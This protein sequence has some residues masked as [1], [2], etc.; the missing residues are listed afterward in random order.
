[1]LLNKE[2]AILAAIKWIAQKEVLMMKGFKKMVALVLAASFAFLMAGCCGGNSQI[3]AGDVGVSTTLDLTTEDIMEIYDFFETE[4]ENYPSFTLGTN[5]NIQKTFLGVSKNFVTPNTNWSSQEESYQQAFGSDGCVINV[6]QDQ[7]EQE[8]K[9]TDGAYHV[10]FGLTGVVTSTAHAPK[11]LMLANIKPIVQ[12][13]LE[14]KC[15][16]LFVSETDDPGCT[17]TYEVYMT[18]NDNIIFG[19]PGINV[20]VLFVRTRTPKA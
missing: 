9:A 6:T 18:M 2:A 19:N 7:G 12:D 10:Y 20:S 11:E 14:S 3:V 13:L 1:M 16:D 8:F 4:L 17:N 15:A 5:Q